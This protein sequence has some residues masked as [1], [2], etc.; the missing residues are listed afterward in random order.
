LR[1]RGQMFHA[2][3][4]AGLNLE[5]FGRKNQFGGLSLSLRSLHLFAI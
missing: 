2:R 1:A 4:R 3:F 5:F